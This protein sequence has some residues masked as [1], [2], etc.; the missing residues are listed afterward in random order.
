LDIPSSA[1]NISTGVSDIQFELC[2][3][4]AIKLTTIQKSLGNIN[5][6]E[7]SVPRVR[8]PQ[9]SDVAFAGLP[10][11]E[12]KAS[13]VILP[14]I[15]TITSQSGIDIQVSKTEP[16]VLQP[17]AMNCA[18]LPE[19]QIEMCS[20][21]SFKPISI[22]LPLVDQTNIEVSAQ[23]FTDVKKPKVAFVAT[24]KVVSENISMPR[25]PA[26]HQKTMTNDF[27]CE[28]S[29]HPTNFHSF[30]SIN[31]PNTKKPLPRCIFEVKINKES[32]GTVP[33]IP[34]VHIEQTSVL[35][36][37]VF[38]FVQPKKIKVTKQLVAV[39]TKSTHVRVPTVSKC[40]VGIPASNTE[41]KKMNIAVVCPAMVELG[42]PFADIK[43]SKSSNFAIPTNTD[44]SGLRQEALLIAS[45]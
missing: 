13:V 28:T 1:V 38:F 5:S 20:L 39:S 9:R 31:I 27:G 2:L 16:N 29:T 21:P 19:V 8:E 37:K 35:P 33:E 40:S 7:V 15:P 10:P 41:P 14:S 44:I 42:K 36:I 11:Y 25:I 24:P 18:V 22:R 12:L 43:I 3:L 32:V 34:D 6:V 30:G 4:P 45:K 26:I 17:T 23:Q